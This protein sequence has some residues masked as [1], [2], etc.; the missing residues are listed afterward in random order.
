MRE[1]THIHTCECMFAPC[2]LNSLVPVQVHNMQ[3]DPHANLEPCQTCVHRRS[4]SFIHVAPFPSLSL[5]Q[6][7]VGSLTWKI[8]F[9]SVEFNSIQFSPANVY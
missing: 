3:T 6:T 1:H 9:S 5:V 2:G 4:P 8:Q 7:H